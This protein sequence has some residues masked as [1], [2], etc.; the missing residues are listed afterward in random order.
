MLLGKRARVWIS[1][2]RRCEIVILLAVL[3]LCACAKNE[4]K[5]EP[6]ASDVK[7]V[8]ENKEAA[9]SFDKGYDLPVDEEEREDGYFNE[10]FK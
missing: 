1:G 5:V 7:E 9:G 8:E 2:W 3:L 4:G 10:N 6:P